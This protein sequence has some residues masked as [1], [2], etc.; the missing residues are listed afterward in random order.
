ML[1]HHHSRDWPWP[2]APVAAQRTPC[3][4]LRRLHVRQPVL[5]GLHWDLPAR[6]GGGEGKQYVHGWLRCRGGLSAL[7]CI[8][9]TTGLEQTDRYKGGHGDTNGGGAKRK[10][11]DGLVAEMW[12]NRALVWLS[13]SFFDS[14]CGNVFTVDYK[15]GETECWVHNTFLLSPSTI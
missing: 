9:E 6:T 4:L 12:D 14:S 13:F 8:L 7:S 5:L 10:S 15:K 2:C 1:G 3:A 11:K